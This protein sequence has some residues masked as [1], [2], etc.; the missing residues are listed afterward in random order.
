VP[1][2]S[3]RLLALAVLN[4][5]F[6]TPTLIGPT[7]LT[8]LLVLLSMMT[9]VQPAPALLAKATRF[10]VPAGQGP[11][12]TRAKLVVTGPL[13]G[14]KDRTPNAAPG[15]SPLVVAAL[16]DSTPMATSDPISPAAA[17][18]AHRCLTL[19][20]TMWDRP[21]VTIGWGTAAACAAD[22]G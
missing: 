16:A 20:M 10:V 12:E 1:D 22:G 11:S 8:P 17:N 2:G 21:F 19:M 5:L 13:L 15:S 6:V 14:S 3:G 9:S 7:V 4:K 18:A